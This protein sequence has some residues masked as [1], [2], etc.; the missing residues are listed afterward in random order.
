M[1]PPPWSLPVELWPVEQTIVKETDRR[2]PQ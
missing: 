2:R 1:R